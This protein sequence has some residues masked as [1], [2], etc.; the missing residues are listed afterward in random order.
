MKKKISRFGSLIKKN[1][2]ALPNRSQVWIE[3]VLY[4]LIGLAIIGILLAIVKPAID[5]KKDQILIE[6]SLGILSDIGSKIED[7]RYYGVGN[8]RLMDIQIKKGQIEVNGKRD[9]IKFLI[10]SKYKYSQPGEN[11]SIGKIVVLT[12]EKGEKYDVVLTLSYKNILNLTY[13]KEDTI[14]SFRAA[15]TPYTISVTNIGKKGDFT[16][17]DFS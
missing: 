11:I 14:K 16:R 7:V 8:S 9:E 1:G 4:T 6:T 17:I 15:P 3:T 12:E 10:E 5:K 2:F 13:N